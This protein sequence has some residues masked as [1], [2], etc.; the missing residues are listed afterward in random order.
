MSTLGERWFK[1]RGMASRGA[2]G[3][4]IIGP[5]NLTRVDLDYNWKVIGMAILWLGC[6]PTIEPITDE[7][8]IFFQKSRPRGKPLA[9]R[10]L[11]MYRP[12]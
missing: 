4:L 3:R 1:M 8:E 6:R 11:S 7:C 10:C 9:S 12:L 5:V 2:S